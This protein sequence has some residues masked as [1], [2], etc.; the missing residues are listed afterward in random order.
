MYEVA[1]YEVFNG[2]K[3]DVGERAFFLQ[4]AEICAGL[5][6]SLCASVFEYSTAIGFGHATEA[7][8][9]SPASYHGKRTLSRTYVWTYSTSDQ[10][11][12]GN[13]L[14]H[15]HASAGI[16]SDSDMFLVATELIF[17]T[18]AFSI[19]EGDTIQDACTGGRVEVT[20]YFPASEIINSD[21]DFA[22]DYAQLAFI[23]QK[24]I[25][26]EIIPSLET[27]A[28]KDQ[29]IYAMGSAACFSGS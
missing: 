17:F 3:E 13:Y 27:V 2:I 10:A 26:D 19:I 21:V 14:N 29:W 24:Y 5:G 20:T 11:S 12:T 9:L 15:K 22:E 7:Q 23:P 25:V 18:T 6:V 28:D 8:V 4:K 16:G 1:D